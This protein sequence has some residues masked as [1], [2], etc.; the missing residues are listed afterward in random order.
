MPKPKDIT[1]PTEAA[2]SKTM[3]FPAFS[4]RILN[5]SQYNSLPHSP[6]ERLQS[7]TNDFDD[8]YVI[9]L[10]TKFDR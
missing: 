3:S 5:N 6:L 10:I 9:H 1:F 7:R 8:R 4:N 2:V